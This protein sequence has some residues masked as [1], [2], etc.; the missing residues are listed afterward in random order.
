LEHLK[1]IKTQTHFL[2]QVG[3]RILPNSN[4]MQ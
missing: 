3:F 1:L 2:S 4:P